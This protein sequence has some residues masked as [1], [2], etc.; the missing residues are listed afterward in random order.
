MSTDIGDLGPIVHTYALRTSAERAFEAY[1][2]RI[3]QWWHPAYTLDPS[4]FRDVRIDP[5]VGG[6]VRAIF[7]NREDDV[8][9]HVETWDPPHRLVHSFRLA[10]P[11]EAPSEVSVTFAPVGAGCE[12][13]F[14]HG[15]WRPENAADRQKFTEWPIILDRFVA[16]LEE[17]TT[18]SRGTPA[19]E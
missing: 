14:C 8:W 17:R 16:L 1:V 18:S 12:M 9:G 7:A 13:T 11:A 19:G 10:Q 15:G 5:W 6:T 4:T 2:E 3:G